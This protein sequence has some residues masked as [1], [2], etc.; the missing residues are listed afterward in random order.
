MINK[1]VKENKCTGCMACS[2]IC[3]INVIK[4]KENEKGFLIPKV[5]EEFCV[6]CG[7]CKKV[8]PVIN[9]TKENINDIKVYACY[10]KDEKI[11]M[12]SSSGGI[13]TL[14]AEEII[15]DGGVVC[16]AQFNDEFEVVHSIVKTTEELK[17]FRGSK[18]VQSQIS[19]ILK[20]VEEYLKNGVKVLFTGTPCQ[21]EG[22]ISY[23]GKEYE[24]LYTQ[25]IICHGVPSPKVWKKYLKYKE[26]KNQSKIKNINF[27]RKDIEG[28]SNYN[29]NFKYN[30]LEENE[31]VKNEKYMQLFL[32]DLTLRDSCYSCNFKKEKRISDITVADYWGI[33]HIDPEINDEKGLSAVLINSLKGEE[34][35]E[36][37]KDNI[38]Y[39]LQSIEGI[40]KYNPS[41][42]KSSKYNLKRDEFFKDLDNTSIEELYEKYINIEKENE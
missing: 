27:R 28:W 36:K 7:K 22:L 24:N 16:G 32:K 8:C 11:R 18:Y 13:F 42:I 38:F 10:N 6:K 12:Q 23:L 21:I 33:K 35:F 31:N 9:N 37:I 17:K 30:D 41:F 15:K 3:P 25:D 19:Y 1:V 29:V 20:D 2:N 14:I 34:L 39:K 40:T 4:I 5:L 26:E